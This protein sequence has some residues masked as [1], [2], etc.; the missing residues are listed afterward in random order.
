MKRRNQW[1][2]MIVFGAMMLGL[3]QSIVAF[4]AECSVQTENTRE[5]MP[6]SDLSEVEFEFL[7]TDVIQIKTTRQ[8]LHRTVV[9]RTFIRIPKVFPEIS[10]PP[11]QA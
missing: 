9:F 10:Y 8:R 2:W 4:P 11:P 7:E 6:E 3:Y 1:F 5:Q